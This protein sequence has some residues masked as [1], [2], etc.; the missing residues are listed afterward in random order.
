MLVIVFSNSGKNKEEPIITHTHTQRYQAALTLQIPQLEAAPSDGCGGKGVESCLVS[1]DLLFPRHPAAPAS[2]FPQS[3]VNQ[4]HHA[5]LFVCCICFLNRKYASWREGILS[6]VFFSISLG[7]GQCQTLRKGGRK[8]SRE[9]RGK[10]REGGKNSVSALLSLFSV[11]NQIII[12]T[13]PQMCTAFTF[14]KMF[15]LSLH[16]SNSPVN[17][18]RWNFIPIV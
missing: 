9:G 8:G 7:F 17:K 6:A 14:C 2:A 1:E 16:P 3:F 4:N 11:L 12:M 13:N 18:K 10:G 5:Y 15:L